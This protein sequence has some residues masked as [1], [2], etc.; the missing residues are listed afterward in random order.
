VAGTSISVR[1]AG[2]GIDGVDNG[3]LA[4]PVR[5]VIPVSAVW[6][7]EM[8]MKAIKGIFHQIKKLIFESNQICQNP[9]H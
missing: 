8:D 9:C 5:H 6:I 3:V 4:A 2:T 7:N 1:T